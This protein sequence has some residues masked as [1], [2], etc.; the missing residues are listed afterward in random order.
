VFFCG[1]AWRECAAH[2]KRLPARSLWSGKTSAECLIIV[3][4]DHRSFRNVPFSNS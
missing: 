2:G 3:P 4:S 1:I